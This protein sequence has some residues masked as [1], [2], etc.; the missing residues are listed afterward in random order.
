VAGGQPRTSLW[1]TF[2]V[3]ALLI[4]PFCFGFGVSHFLHV[5][6]FVSFLFRFFVHV[7]VVL[8]FGWLAVLL[9]GCCDADGCFCFG[10][11][12]CGSGPYAE[13]DLDAMVPIRL[14]SL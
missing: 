8:L 4:V 7:M 13:S 5:S 3:C 12:F 2:V 10:D 9:A 1:E 14:S 6:V 11:E